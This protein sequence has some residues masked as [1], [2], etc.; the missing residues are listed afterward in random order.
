MEEVYTIVKNTISLTFLEDMLASLDHSGVYSLYEAQ[1][2]DFLADAGFRVPAYQVL[3]RDLTNADAFLH[4]LPGDRVVVKV[5][6]PHISHKTELQAVLDV[7]KRPQVVRGIALEML[8]NVPRR[9]A[10]FL[11]QHP[12][13]MPERYQGL[14]YTEMISAIQ[15]D[16]RGILVSEY[17]SHSQ[18]FDSELFVG[19]RWTREF[20]PV[21]S[22]GIGGV[23][24]ELFAKKFRDREAVITGSAMLTTP[25]EFFERFRGTTCYSII[26]GRVRGHKRLVRDEQII[27][28]FELFF[29][30]AD[31][32]SGFGP[33]PFCIEEFEV[34]PFAL[35][36]GLAVP[37]DGLLRFSKRSISTGKR[38]RSKVEALLRPRSVAVLGVSTHQNNVGR[39][40][41]SNLRSSGFDPQKIRVIRPDCD[42]IDSV[43]C[44]DSF[45][46]LDIPVDLAIIAIGA[47]GVPGVFQEILHSKKVRGVIIVP[48]G[49]GEKAS[50]K[51]IEE[52]VVRMIQK[53]RTESPEDAPVV[54]GGNCLGIVSK[55]A[56][57]DTMFIS[58]IKLPKQ[59]G[60]RCNIAFISQSGAYMITR[61]NRLEYLETVYD[62]STGN[63]ID[64][65]ISDLLRVVGD[66]PQVDVIAV[67]VEGFSSMDGLIVAEITRDLRE[68]GKEVI[69][70]KAG[71]T[72][73]GKTA[74]SGH[75]A[76]IAGDYDV[77]V[78]ILQSAGAY[79][80][81][82]FT[83][84]V[85]YLVTAS[86]LHEKQV[87]G[88]K[89]G[90]VS[91]AGYETVGMADSI[92]GHGYQLKLAGFSQSTGERLQ[93]VLEQSGLQDLVTVRNPMDL[94]P[95]ADDHVYEMALSAIMQ[96]PNVDFVVV[97]L[98]PFTTAL[99][100]L[101]EGVDPFDSV[102]ADDSIARR[103]VKLARE[104]PK[105]M[106][107]I[108]DAGRLYDPLARGLKRNGLLVFR[109][110]DRAVLSLGRYMQNRLR[111]G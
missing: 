25:A 16:I 30:M 86:S 92:S 40:I 33:S 88:M 61:M 104:Y 91:N 69:V 37:V 3:D 75:T 102:A 67:Y 28:V 51:P 100:T 66:D 56:S 18:G 35:T 85:D 63:Q 48:G 14:A 101:P 55:P 106:A 8:T 50:G 111:K 74:T 5:V 79:V 68:Q 47:K 29:K 34:N 41:L 13:L 22:A 7:E 73:E 49:M 80:A 44:V 83:D 27:K 97:G 110:A 19:L 20:G 84:F 77:A 98:V 99:K 62:I 81:D 31:R 42:V 15:G 108:V 1:V 60:V 105:P 12:N 38:P 4:D 107:V 93:T 94:T 52:A 64:I 43:R 76:S 45:D 103:L 96:D 53:A 9:Y 39:M 17:I 21:I 36:N 26:S 11:D 95:M 90:M 58:D 59:H 78:T 2:Y 71:R 109:S 82:T 46:A 54:L 89:I 23:D 10:D 24:T 57:I 65:S 70:Y 72:A 6:S 87:T 32:F